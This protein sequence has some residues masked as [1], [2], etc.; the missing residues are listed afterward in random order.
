MMPEFRSPR[1]RTLA[2]VRN[3]DSRSF[4]FG[5][6]ARSVARVINTQFLRLVAVSATGRLDPSAQ[7]RKQESN[8]LSGEAGSRSANHNFK[9]PA[10]AGRFKGEEL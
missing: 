1:R 9:C 5:V 3:V 4:G 10:F 6:G 7:Q 2:L 8:S